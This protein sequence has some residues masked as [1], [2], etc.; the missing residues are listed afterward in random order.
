MTGWG[1]R[2]GGRVGVSSRKQ[3]TKQD[4]HALNFLGE[5]PLKENG[6]GAGRDLE[7]HQRTM[8]A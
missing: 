6:G 5:M 2:L 4:E 3:K 1:G 8:P 7:N